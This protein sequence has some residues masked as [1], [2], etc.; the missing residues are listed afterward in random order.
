MS[1]L[2]DV[3]ILSGVVDLLL[4]YSDK[5]KVRVNSAISSISKAWTYTYDYLKNNNGEYVPNQQL[6]DLWNDAAEKTRLVDKTLAQ[7]LNDKGRFWIHPNLPR[8]TNILKLKDI[9]DEIE[10]LQKKLR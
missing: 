4:K 1:L 10:R 2:G 6:S 5:H 7:S 8:Q 3:V 9:T